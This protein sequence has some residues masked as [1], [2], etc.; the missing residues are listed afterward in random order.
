M[1]TKSNPYPEYIMCAWTSSLT[2]FMLMMGRLTEW[3]IKLLTIFVKVNNLHFVLPHRAE[4]NLV[5]TV[6]Y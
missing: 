2:Y 3:L 1:A 6:I 5:P 4:A